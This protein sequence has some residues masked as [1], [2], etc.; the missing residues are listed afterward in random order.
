[1]ADLVADLASSNHVPSAKAIA[2][3]LLKTQRDNPG[4]STPSFP[5]DS[6]S[7]GS[8]SGFRSPVP[9]FFRAQKLP[10]IP[11]ERTA[12]RSSMTY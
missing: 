5:L 2:D 3:G 4:P 10:P 11:T 7:N 1:M 6:E 8:Q 9:A 12:R